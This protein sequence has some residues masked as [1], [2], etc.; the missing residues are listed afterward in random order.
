MKP[1]KPLT[2]RAITTLKP[3]PEGKRL[4]VWDATIPGFAV[5]ITDSG[6]K[7]FVLVTRYPG[8]K[9]PSP[10]A[11]GTVGAISLATARKRAGEWLEQIADGID[12]KK[13]AEQAKAKAETSTLRAV[14][15]NYLAREGKGLRT[16]D[17][18]R[19]HLERLIYP[20]LGDRPIAE[21]KRSEIVG[22][23]DR[24]EDHNG[25]TQAD[26]V[27]A[28]LRKMMNWYAS[29]DDDFRSP[30]VRGMARTKP[31]D[32]ARKRILSDD[33]LRT[34]WAVAQGHETNGAG[35]VYNYL[36]QFILLT[37]TRLREASNMS[38]SEVSG[39]D[40][41]IP[42]ERY[43]TKLPHLIPLSA[44]A[45]A[46]LASIPTVGG[47]VFTTNGDVAFSGYSKAKVAF[48]ERVLA[49]LR[50]ANPKAEP[51]PHWTP[52]DLRRTARTLMSRAGVSADHAE[53]CLGHV[54]PG[55]R[56]T[57]DLHEYAT[58]KRQAF[59][60]LAAQVDRIVNPRENVVPL[61]GAQ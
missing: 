40:W 41:V 5:R 4:L 12:P 16:A 30:I 19:D 52:H 43:K 22:L 27:L 57:Y 48:D 33:E 59:E 35:L 45:Q 29:R 51:L 56:G 47:W 8:D 28:T 42:A 7:T 54:L 3:A 14:A 17:Q 24:I 36:L 50:I 38:H 53:R 2:D 39:S 44:S 31:K 58:E 49:E 32:L 10:R 26:R 25:A 46:L 23:L 1:K 20:R 37:A 34:V 9:H 21:I 61:R 13:A 6:S 11:I 15:E 60:A 55:I 18:R